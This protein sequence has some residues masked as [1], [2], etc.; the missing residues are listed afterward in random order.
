M[1][2]LG[3]GYYNAV[4]NVANSFGTNYYNFLKGIVG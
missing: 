3:Q 1:Q 2:G 4:K